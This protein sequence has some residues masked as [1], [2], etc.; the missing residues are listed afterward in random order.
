MTEQELENKVAYIFGDGKLAAHWMGQPKQVFGGR[1]PRET[2]RVPGGIEMIE[3]WLQKM[4][5]G[6]IY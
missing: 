1:T 4:Q 2:L 6:F 5:Q 3:E